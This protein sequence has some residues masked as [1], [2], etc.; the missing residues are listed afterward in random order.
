ML[1]MIE[2]K[3][4]TWL[5]TRLVDWISCAIRIIRRDVIDGLGD[6]DYVINF[7]NRWF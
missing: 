1:Y 3:E 7:N 6:Y 4:K 2:Y 5:H